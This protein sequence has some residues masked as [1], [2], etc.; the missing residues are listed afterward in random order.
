MLYTL[1]EVDV[2]LSCLKRMQKGVY[3]NID[4]YID[5]DLWIISIDLSLEFENEILIE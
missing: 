3:V 1:N 5:S 4:S 2:V